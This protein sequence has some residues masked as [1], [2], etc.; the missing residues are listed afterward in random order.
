[1]FNMQTVTRGR[2]HDRPHEKVW[3]RRYTRIPPY[4]GVFTIRK[5]S[6][7][8]SEVAVSSDIVDW[9]CLSK[10]PK[11][12]NHPQD[13]EGEERLEFLNNAK[14]GILFYGRSI[15]GYY[16]KYYPAYRSWFEICLLCHD[17]QVSCLIH[18]DRKY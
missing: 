8:V 14:H 10:I 6:E 12:A 2:P 3:R 7:D 4:D 11:P 1:M 18:S 9:E 13:P 15:V 17:L 5:L 16:L